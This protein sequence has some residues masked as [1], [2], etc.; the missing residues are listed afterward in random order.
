MTVITTCEQCS[1]KNIT[2]L[3]P[4]KREQSTDIICEINCKCNDCKH[5]FIIDSWTNNGQNLGV[6]Y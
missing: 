5:L 1:S 4:E 2:E 3:N 6:L